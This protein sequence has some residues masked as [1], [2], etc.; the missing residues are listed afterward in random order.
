MFLFFLSLQGELVEYYYFWKKTPQAAANRP[1]RRHRRHGVKRA[2][3]RSQRPASSEFCKYFFGLNFWE[4]MFRHVLTC[5]IIKHDLVYCYGFITYWTL[6]CCNTVHHSVVDCST[7][8]QEI[9][10]SSLDHHIIVLCLWARHFIITAG[11][12]PAKCPDRT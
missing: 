6:E 10:G 2:T 9:P 3:T 5:L 11:Y 12:H 4:N 7:W 1:H 8:A